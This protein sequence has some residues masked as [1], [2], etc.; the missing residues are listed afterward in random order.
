MY[1]SEMKIGRNHH[2][3]ECK[4]KTIKQIQKGILVKLDNSGD[5]DYFDETT[6]LQ[7][8]LDLL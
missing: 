5:F 4:D 7:I 8:F 1:Y 2:V 6:F 3:L